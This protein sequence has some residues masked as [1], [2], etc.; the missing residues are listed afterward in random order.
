M[1]LLSISFLGK[2]ELSGLML[3]VPKRV[4][5]DRWKELGLSWKQAPAHRGGGGCGSGGVAW[6]C[7]GGRC[8]VGVVRGGEGGVA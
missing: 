1:Q 4:K 5:G 2:A 3:N 8:G 7:K 6:L